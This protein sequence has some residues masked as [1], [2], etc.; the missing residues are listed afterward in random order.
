[1]IIFTIVRD[2]DIHDK[3][4]DMKFDI[5]IR[6]QTA[7]NLKSTNGDVRTA[8]VIKKLRAV[9]AAAEPE[10]F[11]VKM[12]QSSIMFVWF[13]KWRFHSTYNVAPSKDITPRRTLSYVHTMA[14][15]KS[16]PEPMR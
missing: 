1:M 12:R 7:S 6:K 14:V 11:R 15:A 9:A 5:N 4:R 2:S 10:S 16:Y 8:I 13:L 3:G